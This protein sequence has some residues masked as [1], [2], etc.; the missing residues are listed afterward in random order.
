MKVIW[1]PATIIIVFL[2]LL[3]NFMLPSTYA[4]SDL[5]EVKIDQWQML[6]CKDA[7]CHNA[8]SS[9]QDQRD[10]ITVH[11]GD[12]PER[13]EGAVSAWIKVKL[14]SLSWSSPALLMNRAYAQ[15]IRIYLDDRLV[16]SSERN[17]KYDINKIVLPLSPADSNKE[18]FILLEGNETSIGLKD[19]IV[20]GDFQTLQKQFMRNDMIDFILG[21]SFLMI[22]FIMF[23]C[24]FFV[25]R[26]YIV[27]WGSLCVFIMAFG[28]MMTTYSPFMYTIFAEYG[29]V[30]YKT[31][32]I[33]QMMVFPALFL[34]VEGVFGSGP[35]AI[36]KRFRIFLTLF[37]CINFLF[38]I[39][40]L[41]MNDRL[42]EVY[43]I[44]SVLIFGVIMIIS[45]IVLVGALI[46]YCMKGNKEAYILTTGF[47]CFLTTGAGEIVWYYIQNT[48]YELYYWKFGAICFIASLIII[49]GRRI[50][51]SHGQL[52][53]YSKK[54][55]VYNNEIQRSE[56]MQMISQLAASVAHEVRNPL[57]VTRGFLQLL[58][59]KASTD[60]DR[61]YL[62]L[63]INELDRASNIITD[64]LAFA[65][66]QIEHMSLLDLAEEFQ[67][68]EAILAP[69][70]N[71]Q[72]GEIKLSI[73]DQLWV[74]GNS[75]KF[76]Q[77]II[78]MMK[79]SVESL[80]GQ[81]QIEVW[82]YEQAEEIYIHIR[83]DGVG[84]TES[85]LT[86]LGEP[87]YSNKTKGTGLG[88]MVTFR[89]IEIMQG[90]IKYK[91]VKGKGTEV[92]MC[93][94][95]AQKNEQL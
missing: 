78:N 5:P 86:Q 68:I 29:R 69:L 73:P 7:D 22:S 83:D 1:K 9:F 76:K 37:L 90:T 54:L 14:P 40:N 46:Y 62:M 28:M 85:E 25:N 61:N 67:H 30:Y 71:L 16:Y 47:G 11:S 94:P 87:Y 93:F 91:S 12:I 80:N 43:F 81:G 48:E 6:W 52:V 33:A 32:D 36:L 82:A 77:A 45:G 74:N 64:F 17:F 2:I 4:Q 59:E 66:P 26:N 39:V 44:Y 89:I 31:F 19:D 38:M 3:F 27:G 95:I 63:S 42:N 51:S 23:L 84:M 24:I 70:A 41:L 21:V 10:W 15:N 34:F 72:G 65:K 13:P 20:V 58:G 75:A 50:A 88:L 57:Q 56:K 60:K 55:E 18:L 35:Y 92:I 49:L 8:E 53:A 79:N